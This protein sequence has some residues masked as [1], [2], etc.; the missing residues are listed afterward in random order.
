LLAQHSG[1]AVALHLNTELRAATCSA[2]TIPENHC[3]EEDSDLDDLIKDK[4]EGGILNPE[5][6]R[7]TFDPC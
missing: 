4:I 7:L 2:E 3:F 5:M 1:L 6:R